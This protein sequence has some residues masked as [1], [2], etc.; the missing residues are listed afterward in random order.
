M[1][2]DI[3]VI[4]VDD[5]PEARELLITLLEDFPNIIVTAQSGN[6]DEAL[7]YITANPPD[8]VFLDIHMPKKNGFDLT[9]SMRNLKI[10][11]HIIFIT[12]YDQY[13][14]KAIKNAA[15]DYLLKPINEEELRDT[16]IRFQSL[17]NKVDIV[18]K[19]DNLYKA[20]NGSSRLRFTTRS[21]FTFIN[22][23]EIVYLEAEGNYTSIYL[24]NGKD[25][26]IT[27]SFGQIEEELSSNN[28][29]RINRS[30]IINLKYIAR[31]NKRNKTCHIS[32]GKTEIEFYIPVEQ[33]KLLEAI[34]Y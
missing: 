21:G 6:V 4:I 26:T 7:G 10:K 20:I 8:I 11:S 27:Q 24:L 33:I 34:D 19:M 22:M 32:A 13:A 30:V 29:F 31:V 17:T 1:Q 23:H 3:K 9:N 18:E 15:F 5:E 14:I 2:E 12:A 25:E 28:F 16:I